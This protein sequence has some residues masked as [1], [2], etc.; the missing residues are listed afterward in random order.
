MPASRWIRLEEYPY[1][2]ALSHAALGRQRRVPPVLRELEQTTR[3][4]MRDSIMAAGRPPREIRPR[5]SR[6]WAALSRRSSGF[7]AAPF[8]LSRHLAHLHDKGP[9]LHLLENASS[10]ADSS[11]SRRW[12]TTPGLVPLRKKPAFTK[13]AASGRDPA[14]GGHRG[15]LKLRGERALGVATPS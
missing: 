7:P 1:I 12:L 13:P 6:R 8:Y 4:R 10:R 14:S 3:T 15:V 2:A 5:V 11:V 9:P